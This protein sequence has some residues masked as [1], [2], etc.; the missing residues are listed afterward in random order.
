NISSYDYTYCVADINGEI[1]GGHAVTVIGYDDARVTA[2]G[3]GA[4][5]MVNS[6]GTGWGQ[7]GFWWMSYEAMMSTQISWGYALYATDKIQ[8]EP[9]LIV[10][11]EPTHDD[12]YNLE[13]TVGV[14][15]SSNPI[16]S[17]RFFNFGAGH[18]AVHAYQ[19]D[20]CI[21][22][23][24][25]DMA[26]LISDTEPNDLFVRVDDRSTYN[27]LYGTVDYVMVEDVENQRYAMCYDTP[28]II[29]DNPDD[30]MVDLVL[31]HAAVP[32]ASLDAELDL[33]DGNTTLTWP[34]VPGGNDFEGY[35]IYRDGDLIGTTEDLT[36]VD[37]LTEFGEY[38]Y[39]VASLWAPCPSWPTE[40]SHVNWIVP[41]TSRYTEITALDGTTGDFTLNWEQLRSY[42]VKY[43]DGGSN[44]DLIF[45]DDALPGAMFAQQY[46]AEADGKL[47][48]VRVYFTDS[49]Y[50]MG[51][52]RLRIY[53]ELENDTIGEELFTSGYF[54]PEA[55][56]WKSVGLGLNRQAVQAGDRLWIAVV[57]EEMSVSALG[58][59]TDAAG[60]LTQMSP[61]GENWLP[62]SN[63]A[64]MIR[65]HYGEEEIVGD[66]TGL[67]GFDVYEDDALVATYYDDEHQHSGTLPGAGEY[68]FRVDAIY[69]QGV[70]VGDDL[71]LTW[72]GF[73]AA[74]E[75]EVLPREFAVRN[76]YPNPFNPS[77]TIG[78]TIPVASEL[79][80]RVF[81]TLGR[82]VAS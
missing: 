20:A 3:V 23:D 62:F 68:S 43:D 65:C 59:D 24:L 40:A 71:E 1:R 22:L 81:N 21:V 6:W 77:T 2:D 17:A 32:P 50:D 63:G 30:A 5:K 41:V 35:N 44:M 15:T 51:P 73:T 80:V 11:I 46:E 45:N 78:I 28:V 76:A 13:Y 64:I 8:H 9:S 12:W 52:V 70:W 58:L 49:A 69:Q 36:Y 25:S 33:S 74:E 54:T 57:Y 72:D 29:P 75:L 37:E 18:N 67:L 4:F 26:Y 42:I 66:W 79:E 55:G 82:E 47:T 56:A 31:Y 14:G 48:N 60:R 39:Q 7:S 53:S 10:Y 61:D 27:G 34:A 16:S 38:D 19:E